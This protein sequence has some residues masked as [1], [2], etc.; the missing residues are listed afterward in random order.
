MPITVIGTDPGFANVGVAQISC[1][2]G[3]LQV[4]GLRYIGTK[5]DRSKTRKSY[6]DLARYWEI[7]RELNSFRME[8]GDLNAFAFEVFQPYQGEEQEKRLKAAHKTAMATGVI[9]AVGLSFGVPVIP[10]LPVDIKSRL[11]SSHDRSK[12]AVANELCRLIPGLR[13]QL[14]KLPK[15]QRNH[16]SDAVAVA[17]CG[18]M[19]IA[20]NGSKR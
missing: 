8:A 14:D 16:V 20:K 1:D 6:S 18:L 10:I 3:G 19:E 11:G 4:D 17:Y 5:P 12:D 9:L 7:L 13:E 15:G 2:R